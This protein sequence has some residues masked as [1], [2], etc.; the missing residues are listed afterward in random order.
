MQNPLP[1][2]HSE[3]YEI[4][5]SSEKKWFQ[6][7]YKELWE[8]RDLIKL[9]VRRNIVVVYKQTVLGPIWVLLNPLLS[10]LVYTVIF[11]RVAGLSTDGVPQMLFYLTGTIMWQ[12]L[13]T[14]TTGIANMFIKNQTV[15]GKVYFPRLSIPI[16][17]GLTDLFNFLIQFVFLLCV[18]AFFFIR[19]DVPLFSWT[20]ALLPLLLLQ[21]VMLAMGLGMVLASVTAKYRD[22]VSLTSVGLQLWM[23]LTP[24]VYPLSIT[25]GLASTLM[26]V[27]P[28]TPIVNNF[29]FALLGTGELLTGWWA[30]SAGITIVIFAVGLFWFDRVEKNFVD[31]V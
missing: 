28:M 12:L 22:L 7:N 21:C 5:V 10:S 6:I 23:Y 31:T 16:S 9:F 26:L 17:Q 14:A 20:L 24:V 30:V 29:R 25:D 27:N 1:A 13:S 15:L 3:S 18:Y 2:Q 4:T 19:G 11:G 8:Y